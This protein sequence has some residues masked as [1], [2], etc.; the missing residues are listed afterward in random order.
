VSPFQLA[1]PTKPGHRR[2]IALW[3]VDPHVRIVST[4][5]VPPQQQSWWLESVLGS[6]K[7]SPAGS[8]A[9]RIPP[10]LTQ[11]M[12]ERTD[13]E[14][15]RQAA[16]AASAQTSFSL[17]P[18]LLDMVRKEMSLPGMSAQEAAEHRQ[19]LM[20]ERTTI[21]SKVEDGWFQESYSFCEH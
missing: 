19:R 7:E 1:D 14:A 5:N 3:L 13:I 17:P 6:T 16:S 18:E 21:S 10:E 20:D 2:F 4:A 9:S 12:A 11:L 15:L 8:S